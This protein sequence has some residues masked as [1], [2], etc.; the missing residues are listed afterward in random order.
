MADFSNHVARA[1]ENLRFIEKL[2]IIPQQWDWKVTTG[3]YVA[4]HLVN[5]HLARVG[6]LHF[7]QHKQVEDAISPQSVLVTARLPENV[8]VAYRILKNLS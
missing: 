7:R 1:S 4:V 5:A 8:Y 2:N 6:N 3:F